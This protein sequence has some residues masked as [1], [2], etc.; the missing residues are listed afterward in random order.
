MWNECI[1]VMCS[2][3]FSVQFYITRGKLVPYSECS[4]K[5][6]ITAGIKRVE[7]LQK[8]IYL[9]QTQNLYESKSLLKKFNIH[10]QL[11]VISQYFRSI[12][13]YHILIKKLQNMHHTNS[14]PTADLVTF[15]K[16]WPFVSVNIL[17]I[18]VLMW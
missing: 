12:N 10:V 2:S 4:L 14:V 11:K 5:V 7:T 15:I 18:L 6:I 9:S 1:N 3:L 16:N 13:K 8:G 17:Q